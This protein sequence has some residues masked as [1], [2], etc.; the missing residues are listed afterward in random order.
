MSLPL[1]LSTK[2]LRTSIRQVA[3]SLLVLKL[4]FHLGAQEILTLKEAL[5]RGEAHSEALLQSDEEI[6]QAELLRRQLWKLSLP[7]LELRSQI[8][9]QDQAHLGSNPLVRPLL[10]SPLYSLSLSLLENPLTFYKEYHAISS[11]ELLQRVRVYGKEGIRLGLYRDIIK[12]YYT[13]LNLETNLKIAT[14]ILEVMVDRIQELKQRVRLGKSRPVEVISQEALYLQVLTQRKETE[15]ALALARN[16]LGFLI[17]VPQFSGEVTR[18]SAQLPITIP[19]ITYY[20]ARLEE[21]PELIAA[22]ARVELTRKN[23][24]IARSG[25]F[26]SLGA[27]ANYYLLRN[28][29]SQDIRWD[30]SAFVRIPL[31]SWGAV[32]DQIYIAQSQARQAELD[33]LRLK[34]QLE[35]DLRNTYDNLRYSLENLEHYR[36]VQ[37]RTEESYRLLVQ[38]FSRGMAVNLEVLDALNQLVQARLNLALHELAVEAYNLELRLFSGEEIL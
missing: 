29:F 19:P 28:G 18:A 14:R 21:R 10:T 27:A 25:H 20:L 30:I 4:P 17:G 38:D 12:A 15:R 32:Q 33:Y 6:R 11:Q 3:L 8:Q 26:P 2:S 34:R 36:E 9:W 24:E 7:S 16:L 31:F 5:Q 22:R 1:C 23:I 37:E 35:M 13:L